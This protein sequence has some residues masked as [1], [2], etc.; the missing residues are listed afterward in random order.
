MR[1]L[2]DLVARWRTPDPHPPADAGADAFCVLCGAPTAGTDSY[3]TYGVC[4]RCGYHHAISAWKRIDLLADPGTFREI[5]ASTTSIDP[6]QFPEGGDYRKQLREAFRRT[7]LREAVLTGVCEMQ[8]RQVVL[9]L[10]DFGFLGGSMGVVVGERVAQAFE[11][12]TRRR[13][14]VI[15]VITSSGT[16]IREGVLALMQMAKTAAA[17][18]RHSRRRLAH[19]AILGN[20]S[21]GGV[22][23]SF[24]NLADVIVAEPA[25]LLGFA[26]LRD[27]E[28]SELGPLP[29]D[30]HTAEAHL[31]H[32]LIDQIVPRDRHRPLL[33][34]LIDL[35]T[36]SY[37]LEITKRLEPF[38]RRPLRPISPWQEVQLARHERRP[39]ALDFIGRMTTSFVPLQGDR[40]RGDD[41]A[42]V[43][44]LA[45]LGGRS[46]VLIGHQRAPDG[47]HEPP[48]IRPEGFRKGLRA[49][50]LAEKFR[51]PLLTLIDNRGAQPNRDA[52]EHGL[53]H[54]LA[55]NLAAMVGLRT[56]TVA[57]IIGE[58]GGEGALAFGVADRVFMLEHAIFS[59]ASPEHAAEQLLRRPERAQRMAE[60]LRL[61]ALD[62]RRLG[63]V[64]HIVREPR[65]GA[66]EN[67]AAAA[68][69][70]KT[71]LLQELNSLARIPLQTLL[72]QRYRRYRSAGVY[73][74]FFRVSLARNIGDL[75]AA[76]VE[77]LTRRLRRLRLPSRLEP[78]DDPSHIPV[79]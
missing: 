18:D 13:L 65:G 9:I 32:G 69:G 75:R 41:P 6:L 2:A 51:L 20:P 73:Q 21:T 59:V 27:L 63:V 49:M 64:D 56:P 15:S 14:P 40:H 8:G 29:P 3:D 47:A 23:A 68:A 25:A 4:G 34:A 37:R 43:A 11:Y 52:E 67:H 35:T 10:L 22:F 53:G 72:R 45:D 76:I 26:S 74:N 54:A 55:A 17:V 58:G 24:A 38:V 57:V 42:V 61:T 78:E 70:L 1:V 5:H 60:A 79:D 71:V 66:H 44:G 33:T 28:R 30:A 46:V 39:T 77:R 48:L 12:A 7:G 50:R 31:H 36:P 62:A 19:L 16:R